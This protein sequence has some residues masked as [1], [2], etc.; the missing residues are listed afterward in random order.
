MVTVHTGAETIQGRKLFKG[1]NYMRKYGITVLAGSFK[2]QTQDGF[3][4]YFFFC[5][6]GDLKNK[7]HFL[8]KKP[9]VR[10]FSIVFK[11]K[12]L[13]NVLGHVLGLDFE[14][15]KN[16]SLSL[17]LYLGV[18]LRRFLVTSSKLFTC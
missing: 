12:Q 15:C 11:T 8:K 13:R 2:F 14:I 10:H 16:P 1:G 4:E 6:F 7:S 9:L 5:R 18:L 17:G 3:L